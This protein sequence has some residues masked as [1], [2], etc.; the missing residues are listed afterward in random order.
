[1]QHQKYALDYQIIYCT[2]RSS[3]ARAAAANPLPL[4]LC[5]SRLW[6]GDGAYLLHLQLLVYLTVPTYLTVLYLLH[7]APAQLHPAPDQLRAPAP[8]LTEPQPQPPV[9]WRCGAEMW[10]GDNLLEY[11]LTW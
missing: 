2:C 6:G 5:Q 11:A 3:S 9:G 7:P 1:M 4:L 8:A 10:G